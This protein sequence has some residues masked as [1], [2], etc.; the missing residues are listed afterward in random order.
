MTGGNTKL[1]AARRALLHLA[2]HADALRAAPRAWLL[3]AWWRLCGKRLRS[4]SQMAPLL[5]ASPRA[6]RLWLMAQ[7]EADKRPQPVDGPAIAALVEDGPGIERTLASLRREGI[8]HVAAPAATM[9]DAGHAAWI[10][11][12]HAGDL[13]AEGA[14]GAYRHAAAQAGPGTHLL[15]ADDDIIGADGSRGKPHFKPDWNADLFEHHDF[16]TGASLLRVAASDLDDLPRG[17]RAEALTRRVLAR[18][19]AEGAQPLHVRAILHHRCDRPAPIRPAPIRPA[20]IRRAASRHD[21][22]LAQPSVTIIVPTRNRIDLL[23]T[24]LQGIADTRYAGALDVIVIDNDSDDPEALAFLKGL[25]PGTARVLRHPGAF[26]FAAMNNRAVEQSTGR[27]VC[28]L[29]NDIEIRDP[30]WLETLVRQALRPEVG[31]VGPQLLYPD[32][33]I[34]HAGVVLGVG[35]GAAHAHRLLRP[36]EEGYFHRHALPQFVSAVTAACLVAQRSRILEVGGMDERNFAVSF[37]DVDLCLKL[38]ARGWQSF[39]EPRAA[40]IH[41]ESVSRGLDRDPVGAARLAGELAA[42]KERWGT[43]GEID[44]FHHPSLSPF[45]ERFVVRF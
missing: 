44:P 2:V 15:Y 20:P 37:N 9:R 39:Y 31:A 7:P 4:R 30:H 1:D 40:L 3:A 34:Q 24:C 21:P 19:V 38:N 33:R 45:S 12:L 26:N 6:Y 42:L 32:G 16:L 25:E 23:R 28:L 14:G 41:H 17:N 10:M 5:G 36:E 29:N 8:E 13:L 35:G 18:T 27:M 11:P 43:G 22:S